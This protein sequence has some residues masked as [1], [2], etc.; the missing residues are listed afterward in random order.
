M[1][2][3]SMDNAKIKTR[4]TDRPELPV[5]DVMLASHKTTFEFMGWR[6]G[7]SIMTPEGDTGML[8]CYK[9]LLNPFPPGALYSYKTFRIFNPLKI[10][11]ATL[12]PDTIAEYQ[13]Q[14]KNTAAAWLIT[15][16]YEH[17][18]V[19]CPCQADAER[20]NEDHR[21]S[22]FRSAML[23]ALTWYDR[24]ITQ[25]VCD[26]RDRKLFVESGRLF[27][28]RYYDSSGVRVG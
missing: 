15:H 8:V 5:E 9:P 17:A 16:W 3:T 2:Q 19:V 4:T 22:N 14:E 26:E 13:V 24:F 27:R 11:Y 6:F 7:Q 10:P 23:S 25:P 1:H 21:P 12:P 28:V 20:E 18:L